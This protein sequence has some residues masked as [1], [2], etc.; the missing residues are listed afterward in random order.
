MKAITYS[1]DVDDFIKSLDLSTSAKVVRAVE[2][3]Q[4][5]ENGEFRY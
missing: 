2:L 5:P 3:Q 1:S 4:F